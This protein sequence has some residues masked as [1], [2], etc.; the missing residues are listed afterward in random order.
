MRSQQALLLLLAA[1]VASAASA[2]SLHEVAPSAVLLE[3]FDAGWGDK[4][5]HSSADK[6]TG[7]FEAVGDED[8]ELRVRR[9]SEVPK[10]LGSSIPAPTPVAM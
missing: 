1:A 9:S 8:A 5:V 2:A 6:Y 7:V 3:S 10:I 4:W